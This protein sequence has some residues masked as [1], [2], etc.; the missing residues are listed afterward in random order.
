MDDLKDTRNIMVRL[1]AFIVNKRKAILV[2]FAIACIYCAACISKVGVE[3]D[4]TEYLPDTTETR[5]GL[6]LMDTEFVTF[7]SG[8]I[9]IANITYEH[10]LKLADE[11][12]DIK[13][14]STVSFYDLEDDA[15]E[16]ADR[17]DY[18]QDAAALYT[19]MFEDVEDSEMTQAA[20]AQVRS[21][22]EG[23][24]AYVYTTVDKDDAADLRNDMKL[25]ALIVVSIILL[26]LLFTS[27][28]YMEILIFLIVFGVAAVLNAGTNYW[29]GTISFITNAVGTILQLALA[30]DYAIILFHRFME[31]REHMETIDAITTA[32]SKAIPEISS[33]SLTTISGMLAMMFMQFGIGLDMGRVLMKAIIFSMISVFLLMPALI[34]MFSKAIDRTVHR[35]FVPSIRGWGRLVVKVRYL[36][37]PVFLIITGV[38][39]LWS[40]KCN[41]IYDSNSIDSMKK[42]EYLTARDRIA[43]TFEVT[44]TMA[45]IVPKEDYQKEARLI[46]QLEQLEAVDTVTGLSNIEVDDNGD[47]ILVDECN[48]REFSEIADVDLDVVRALY[49]IY[50]IDKKQYGAFIKNVDDYKIPIIDMVDFIYEQK[51]SGALDFDEE[52]SSDI[53]DLYDAMCKARE[54][55][56]GDDYSRIVFT[57]RGAVEGEE[58][59]KVIDTIRN[60][61]RQYYDETYVVGDATSNYDLSD[62][63]QN[64]NTMISILTALFVGVILLFTFQSASLPF[65]L[66]LVIQSSI[67]I[68]FSFPYL[69]DTTMFFLC[70][71][72]V[73]AIQMGA[74][75]DYAIVMTSRYMVLRRELPDKKEAIIES[76]NQAFPTI[77]TSGTILTCA[78]FAIGNFTANATIASLGMA[79]GRGTLISIALVMTVLPQILLVFDKLI[80]KTGF[81]KEVSE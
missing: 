72:I 70:Y 33:S 81:S 5:Q 46:A 78:S 28:T 26:V 11:L 47:F 53:D 9:L 45:V 62:S 64:D 13:G 55:L 22:L 16:E 20:I 73:S 25:I 75:I 69:T 52:Q 2:L 41:Y 54:Q 77:V 74:T 43:E 32:L 34:V 44:N 27:Q 17:P 7:G 66:V 63:F 31:E 12:G 18:Y 24:N 3:N 49:Y 29:F 71:L 1:A 50:A 36:V 67:F 42:N 65:L 51:E 38:A 15:Y 56:E 39:F 57:L 21:R 37:L 6:D 79:L 61:S 58:T 76:I 59:F 23:Y 35:N 10:A 19:I 68:N 48:P 4:L 40:M 8:K 60:I 80:E 14:V 30:I